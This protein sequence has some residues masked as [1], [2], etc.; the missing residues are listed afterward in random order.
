MTTPLPMP[1]AQKQAGEQ[2]HQRKG[3]AY[4]GQRHAAQEASHYP[5][6]HNIVALLKQVTRNQ[7]KAE[8]NQSLAN[9]AA[10]QIAFQKKDLPAG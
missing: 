8:K 2:R 3:A 9:A 7:R 6:I 5:G 4:G 1:Q 10:G